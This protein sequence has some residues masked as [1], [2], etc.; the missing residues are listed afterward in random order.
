VIGTN[1][2][3]TI[4]ALK[5]FR[6]SGAKRF[7]YVSSNAVYGANSLSFPALEEE[8]TVCDPRS[9]YAISKLAAELTSLRLA[10]LWKADV[11]IARL[12]SVFGPWERDTGVRDTLN[13]MLQTTLAAL[14]GEEA[15]LERPC[16]RDWIYSRDVA[17]ALLELTRSQRLQHSIYNI[18]PGVN[19]NWTI[20]DWC[21]RLPRP[22]PLPP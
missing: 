3:G 10:D 2:I 4:N 7:V 6:A 20:A 11:R 9:L 18:G 13:P 14:R 19:R 16:R 22:S 8:G 5:A 21:D 15:V 12:S 1:V 17:T